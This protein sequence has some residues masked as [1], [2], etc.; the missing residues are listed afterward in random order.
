[1]FLLGVLLLLMTAPTTGAHA[2]TLSVT[3]VDPASSAENRTVTVTVSGDFSTDVSATWPNFDLVGPRRLYGTTLSGW[4]QHSATVMFD[5]PDECDGVYDL[6]GEQFVY[7]GATPYTDTLPAAFTVV[8]DLAITGLDPATC[9]S[10]HG[11]LTLT[12]YGEGFIGWGPIPALHPSVVRWN[13]TAVPTTVNSATVLTAT[14]PAASLA[15]GTALVTVYNQGM[16]PLAPSEESNRWAFEVTPPTPAISSLSPTSAV[17]GGAAFDLTVTGAKFIAGSVARWNATVLA[18]TVLSPTQLRATVPASLIAAAGSAQITVRNGAEGSPVSSA[19]TFTVGLSLPALTAITPDHVWA[20]YVKDDLVLTASGTGFVN[21]AH[22]MLGALEKAATA[23]VGATQLTVPLAAADIAVPG[24]IAVGV[25][26]PDGGLAPA[27]KPLAVVAE[28]TTPSVTISG[29]DT[30][31]HNSPVT[32]TFAATDTQSGVQKIQY[33]CPPAVATWTDAAGYTVPTSTQGSVVVS[34]Q[35]LDWCNGVGSGS[36]TVKIDTT[37]PR[38][39][40]QNAVTVKRGRTAKL[41]YRVSEPADLSPT[42]DVVIRIK[43]SGRV[44]KTM[45]FDDTPMNSDRSYSFRC[46]LK[47][48]SY[49]WY[50]YATDLAGNQQASAASNSLRV[51]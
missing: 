35:A 39:Q 46:T 14:V 30:A 12:V 13:G 11:D 43:K 29:A 37:A 36:A 8:P 26:N 2:F 19:V 51:K 7:G 4:T 31:W 42:A 24:T 20:G 3:A 28:T 10:D 48:G 38:T 25:K 40:A 41:K 47:K 33:R 18:T 45:R 32:L 16:L 17:A 15:P 22:I 50:V 1:M 6:Y 49:R 23:F 27:T 44:V 5:L 34:V 9:A 21:G